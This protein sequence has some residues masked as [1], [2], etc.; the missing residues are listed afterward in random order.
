[1][2]VIFTSHR[3]TKARRLLLKLPGNRLI[4]GF[5]LSDH[6][7]AFCVQPNTPAIV[8]ARELSIR[9]IM[10]NVYADLKFLNIYLSSFWFQQRILILFSSAV[11]FCLPLLYHH[12]P[13]MSIGFMIFFRDPAL[14][15]SGSRSHHSFS[16]LFFCSHNPPALTG[17][18]LPQGRNS[19]FCNREDRR[20]PPQQP[21]SSASSPRPP[22]FL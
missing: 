21:C 17:S 18:P 3:K 10:Q 20:A 5:G 1:M 11:F 6:F 15:S 14:H 4:S 13:T 22:A 19:A 9:H 2:T 7:A 12:I 16:P 8:S